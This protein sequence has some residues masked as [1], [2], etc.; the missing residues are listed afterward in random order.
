MLPDSVADAKEGWAVMSKTNPAARFSNEQTN[1]RTT[2]NHW[3]E[4]IRRLPDVRWEK[5][6]RTRELLE[7]HQYDDERILD[8]TIRRLSEEIDVEAD[9]KPDR[10]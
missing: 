2:L 9:L 7:I 1:P 6:N 10:G 5:V 3:K 8:E 4:K